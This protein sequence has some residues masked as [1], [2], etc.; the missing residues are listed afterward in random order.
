MYLSIMKC[1]RQPIHKN[2]KIWFFDNYWEVLSICGV[3][4]RSA[5]LP[6]IVR[7]YIAVNHQAVID[8]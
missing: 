8:G 2:F 3:V 1:Y 6:G 5:V 7:S 4:K